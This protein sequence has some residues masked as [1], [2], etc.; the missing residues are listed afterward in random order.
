M[1]A[2]EETGNW[3][4][5]PRDLL[6]RSCGA[7]HSPWQWMPGKTLMTWRPADRAKREE[8]GKGLGG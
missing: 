7:E 6:H 4:C 2:M 3:A 8:G 1:S 5:T